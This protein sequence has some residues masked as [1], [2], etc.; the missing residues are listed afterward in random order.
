MTEYYVHDDTDLDQLVQDH[1]DDILKYLKIPNQRALE[2]EEY[3]SDIIT[4]IPG[5]EARCQRI[6]YFANTTENEKIYM[7][8]YVILERRKEYG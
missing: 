8:M 5:F 2:L 7:N 6:R 3:V 4:G 1:R